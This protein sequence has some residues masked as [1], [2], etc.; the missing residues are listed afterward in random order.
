MTKSDLRSNCPINYALEYLGDKWTL[1]VIRDMV[2]DGKKFYKEF[3][4]SQEG[5]ATNILSDRL[6]KLET[7]GIV[8]SEVYEKQRTQKIY[9]L[10]EKGI[11]LI[12][13]LIELLLWSS[14]HKSGLNIPPDFVEK[15][16]SDKNAVIN[17]ITDNVKCN[18][19]NNK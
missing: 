3:L 11:D 10:T 5:I 16:K 1:L 15:L 9:S 12:P 14:N 17:A 13:I 4:T 2:F 19:Q 18:F 7:A 8:I 6:K